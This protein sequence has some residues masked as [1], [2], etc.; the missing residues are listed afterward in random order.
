MIVVEEITPEAMNQAV[1]QLSHEGFFDH[2]T[3]ITQND[4][5]SGDPY[6]WPPQ[7]PGKGATKIGKTRNNKTRGKTM[8]T[9]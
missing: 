2:L 4:L 7:I 9:R 8:G 5:A 6:R 3:A 1:E